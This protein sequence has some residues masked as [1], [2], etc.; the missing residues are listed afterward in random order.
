MKLKDIA[1][2]VLQANIFIAF[3][4]ICTLYCL[5]GQDVRT[6]AFTGSADLAFDWMTIFA[7]AFFMSEM[8]LACVGTAG[9]RFSFFFFL[10]LVSTLTLILD[11]SIVGSS[12]AASIV[13]KSSRASRAG[14]RA[15]RVIKIIRLIRL[16]RI[17]KVFKA[18]IKENPEPEQMADDVSDKTSVIDL[19]QG[20]RKE[21]QIGNT[22]S[23]LTSQRIIIIVLLMVF[24]I[25]QFEISSQ[26]QTA[27]DLHHVGLISVARAYSS[28]VAACR[29]GNMSTSSSARKFYERI[30]SLFINESLSGKAHDK[31]FITWLGASVSENS[32]PCVVGDS[33]PPPSFAWL[34]SNKESYI[35]NIL[36]QPWTSN[37]DPSFMATQ[38]ISVTGVCPSELR[39]NEKS[40]INWTTSDAVFEIV[41]DSY[42]FVRSEAFLS[43]YRTLVICFILGIGTFA[44]SE[45]AFKLALEPIDRMIDKVAKI[46]ENP[47]QASRIEDETMKRD[48]VER[49]RRL[50]RY[51]T[52]TNFFSRWM[53]K[54]ALANLNSDTLETDILEKT[55]IRI[56]GLLALGFGEAG[57]AIVAHNMKSTDPSIN[58]MLPGKRVDAVFVSI[59]ITNFSTISAVLKDKV[60]IFINRVAEIV[61]GVG[62]EFHGV[63]NKSDGESSLMIWRL[64]EDVERNKRIHDMSVVACV[65]TCIAISRSLELHEYSLHP[66]LMQ[67]VP[68]F[69]VELNFGLHRGWAIEGAIGSDLKIDP[70]YLGP[71]V[72]LVEALAAKN[73][74]YKTWILASNKMMQSCSPSL[75]SVL[76][77]RI[78]RVHI[79]G[80][81]QNVDIYCLDLDSRAE[82][83]TQYEIENGVQ[84]TSTHMS[85]RRQGRERE[86]RKTSRW[87]T[88][89]LLFLYKDKY[90]QSLRH[91]YD[92]NSLFRELFQ[93]GFLN[94]EAG[95]WDV[96]K[97]TFNDILTL[98]V[99]NDGPSERL[100]QFM[101]SLN[102]EA[103]WDWKGIRDI[104]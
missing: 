38:G 74:H 59:R 1:S 86:K 60:V 87:E 3:G 29:S 65:K 70:S 66:A 93:K 95:E 30:L 46:R 25:P 8:L 78:D 72:N 80:S 5:F 49:L 24:T 21:N 41:V 43:I 69:K 76:F 85:R 39:W 61:H 2:R 63:P 44:F 12:L 64:S 98:H 71:D 42:M 20:N 7:F 6:I 35:F 32:D 56:S 27:P 101:S 82:I 9:Y 58:V 4:A 68:G 99:K 73:A 22:L 90:F 94:Y 23:K 17:S 81:R 31:P 57:A 55:I 92:S 10:D 96:A 51:N 62:N 52:A 16:L 100:L 67:K 11:L 50:A 79:V 18:M 14:T 28:F 88:D 77:R 13:S 102:N 40:L 45:G 19:P 84:S 53:A 15:S 34:T 26:F 48:E 91:V 75:V 36:L 83:L 54:R 33:G 47:L 104:N 89:M 97:D 103:P 37:C